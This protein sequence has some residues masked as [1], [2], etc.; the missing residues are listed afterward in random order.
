VSDRALRALRD[1]V[2]LDDG[3]TSPARVRSVRPGL[4]EVEIAEGRKRQVRRRCE[5]VGHR[6]V[7]LERVAFGPLRLGDLAE[8]RYRRLTAAEIERLREAAARI[9]R[10]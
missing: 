2:D 9:S 10:P 4:L 8:G 1:G 3:R 5:A 6:V 7:E